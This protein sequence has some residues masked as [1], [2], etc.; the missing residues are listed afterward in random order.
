MLER[1]D[2][3]LI[4][5]AARNAGKTAFASRLIRR[6]AGR[7]DVYGV[8]L[9]PL[10]AE[11]AE[12]VAGTTLA[13][14]A[15]IERE[16]S[17]SG[18]SDTGRMLAAGAKEAHW[19][20]ARPD[21]LEAAAA[22]LWSRF[23]PGACVVAEGG[24]L[25]RVLKP[26]L[27]V[28]IHEA[29]RKDLKGSFP[30]LAPLADRIICFDGSG[31]DPGPGSCRFIDGAWILR[32]PASAI[33]LAGGES[34]R[35]GRDKA[36]LDFDGRPLVA[37]VIERLEALFDDIVIGAGQPGD[38][39]F[40]GRPIAA[41]AEPGQGPL[42]GIASSLERIASDLALVTAC[43]IPYPDLGL[44]AGLL[45]QAEGYDWVLPRTAAGRYEPLFAVY[46]RTVAPAARA[47]LAAGERS[48]LGLLD[49]VRVRIV[50]LPEGWDMGNVNT[51]D[52]YLALRR[53]T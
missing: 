38:Y 32:P 35:M 26:G 21:H 2:T 29:G 11:P 53:R 13:P 1:P 6:Q 45:D 41:D 10:P 36:L 33:V 47:L 44:A 12:A 19:I 3:I 46:R 5:S 8:K 31:W 50:P 23:P 9:T 42:M 15:C 17:P 27:F 20:R 28:L 52:D 51:L 40:L 34:R 25:R 39:A 49:K 37:R 48:I 16:R 18:S 14:T 22:G 43:D 30:E 7:G 4:G 24:S